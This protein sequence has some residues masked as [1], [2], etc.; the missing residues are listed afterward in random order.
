[1]SSSLPLTSFIKL[2]IL[3]ESLERIMQAFKATK[4]DDEI[5]IRFINQNHP[6]FGM[7]YNS[8]GRNHND[9]PGIYAYN[10]KYQATNI[11]V[12]NYAYDQKLGYVF[13]YPWKELTKQGKCIIIDANS[14]DR[15]QYGIPIRKVFNYIKDTYFHVMST[16]SNY[17]NNMH[18]N[19]NIEPHIS[20]EGV[21]SI[22]QKIV[23]MMETKEGRQELFDMY[24]DKEIG[25]ENWFNILTNKLS[26]TP[27]QITKSFLACGIDSIYDT[28]FGIINRAEPCQ[29]LCFSERYITLVDVL[30][31]RESGDWYFSK[32]SPFKK[33]ENLLTKGKNIENRVPSKDLVLSCL[34]VSP[35]ETIQM[36]MRAGKHKVITPEL[37]DEASIQYPVEVLKAVIPLYY[38]KYL[39]DTLID[40]ALEKDPYET[41]KL[42]TYPHKRQELMDKLT[43]E[44][45][46]KALKKN[47]FSVFR[48]LQYDKELR[49]K[50]SEEDFKVIIQD[51]I[52]HIPEIGKFTVEELLA[53]FLHTKEGAKYV[54]DD[55]LGPLL[56]VHPI[57]TLETL[58]AFN[59][60]HRLNDTLITNMFK[61]VRI[62]PA[63]TEYIV[64]T[65]DNLGL[66]KKYQDIIDNLDNGKFYMG[67]IEN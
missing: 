14:T 55:L 52:D 64:D 36:L 67:N 66:S 16:I 8:L 65:M 7:N 6:R 5:F 41:I 4:G 58:K 12:G 33:L 24:Y 50:V 18:V 10:V 25:P 44:R 2:S 30:H 11:S 63:Q 15:S 29:L 28:G 40:R 34:L 26:V 45:M 22:T 60:E 54:N 49:N 51:M 27:A 9:P 43:P 62:G 61:S 48:A 39:T 38:T 23:N 35:Y 57:E 19:Y 46:K 31:K 32:N 56:E 53:S 21:I 13:K 59:Q 3:N 1:M 37:T 42:L 17:I 20:P 47:P